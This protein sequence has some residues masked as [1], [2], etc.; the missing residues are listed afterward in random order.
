MNT[1]KVKLLEELLSHL[2]SSQGMDLK[3]LL[4]QS[5]KP[6]MMEGS[7]EEEAL[8]SPKDEMMEDG[9]P[10]G[11]SIEKVSVLGKKPGTPGM[12]DMPDKS[13]GVGVE[14]AGMD[15]MG[16]DDPEMSDDELEELLKKALA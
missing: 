4:D 13:G 5:K 12:D 10:K 2:S 9:K 14:K 15:G 11:L 6:P 3:S 1:L 7:P 16:G 8:E